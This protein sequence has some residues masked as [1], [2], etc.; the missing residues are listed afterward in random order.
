MQLKP[1]NQQVVAVVGASSGIGRETAIQFAARGA[2]LVVSARSEPGLDSLVDEIRQMGGEAIAVPADVTNF[3]QVKAIADHTPYHPAIRT[4]R[5]L[6]A[7]SRH[8]SLRD[9]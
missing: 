1:I 7:F 4:T 8:Q 3:E 6:G 2:K 9:V 5:H